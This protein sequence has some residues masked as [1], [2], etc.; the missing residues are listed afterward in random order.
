MSYSLVSVFLLVSWESVMTVFLL[1]W[2]SSEILNRGDKTGYQIK[3]ILALLAYL[4][5]YQAWLLCYQRKSNEVGVWD[6]SIIGQERWRNSSWSTGDRVREEGE[7]AAVCLL[8]RLAWNCWTEFGLE[9]E[10]LN[11][12]L[13]FML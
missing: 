1:V 11:I 5:F 4:L 2:S 3:C 8:Q 13:V 12:L 10:S 6:K 7:I 9:K